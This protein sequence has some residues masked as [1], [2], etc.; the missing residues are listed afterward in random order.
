MGRKEA[1]AGHGSCKGHAI[2]PDTSSCPSQ[3]ELIR[4][5]DDG[6]CKGHAVPPG[7]TSCPDQPEA[8]QAVYSL[9]Q[10]L[11]RPSEKG[12]EADKAGD[13]SWKGHAVPP[14]PTRAARQ[15][16]TVNFSTICYSQSIKDDPGLISVRYTSALCYLVGVRRPV[17]SSGRRA[18]RMTVSWG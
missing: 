7:T 17:K 16:A 3:P 14:V 15:Q 9:A 6:S 2:P 1:K 12:P 5:M 11:A 8:D 10:H 18:G 4:L 13:G